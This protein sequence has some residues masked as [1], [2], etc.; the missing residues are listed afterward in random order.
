MRALLLAVALAGCASLPPGKTPDPQDPFERFNRTS[1]GFNETLDKVLLKPV[2]KA[3]ETVA[4]GFVQ[5]GI[6]NFFGN[7]SDIPTALNDGLQGRP[8]AAGV[9]AARVAINSTIGLLGFI[10]F[11]TGMGLPRERQD[12]GLT[13]GAWGADSGPYLV[14]PFFGPSSVRDTL[15]L[16]LDW[17]ADPLMLIHGNVAARNAAAATRTVDRR[18]GV[19]GADQVVED[20]AFDKYLLV[21]DAYLAHRKSRV[22]EGA[23]QP[24][25]APEPS[26]D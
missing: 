12:F 8:K 5:T 22:E 7:L 17:A 13:F 9:H 11:A 1:E 6:A 14:L 25:S 23:N 18:A 26:K 15:G 3:Y 2:A 19:L 16:P 10:D 21:R 4:P 20:A 24:P